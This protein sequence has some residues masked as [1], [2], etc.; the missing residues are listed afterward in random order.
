MQAPDTGNPVDDGIAA[1]ANLNTIEGVF[2]AHQNEFITDGNM[3]LVR[4]LIE[5]DCVITN[6]KGLKDVFTQIDTQKVF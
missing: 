2:Q 1:N 4:K 5:H 6:I 3:D